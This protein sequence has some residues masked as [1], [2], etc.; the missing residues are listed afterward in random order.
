MSSCWINNL[1]A[2]CSNVLQICLVEFSW[3]CMRMNQ[4]ICDTNHK[5]LFFRRAAN[6]D[7]FPNSSGALSVQLDPMLFIFKSCFKEFCFMRLNTTC[8]FVAI[9]SS[10]EN[11][12]CSKTS[13]FLTD[14]MTVFSWLQ[15]ATSVDSFSFTKLT[16]ISLVP[17]RKISWLISSV[18]FLMT[19]LDII[20]VSSSFPQFHKAS[21]ILRRLYASFF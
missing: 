8:D 1:H 19:S 9:F 2:S 20:I 13:L 21:I 12:M 18:L 7:R 4:A 6:L 5:I 17:C 15:W 11:K 10:L 14:R 3:Q 16:L